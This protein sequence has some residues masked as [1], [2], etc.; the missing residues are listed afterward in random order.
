MPGEVYDLAAPPDD[1]WWVITGEAP[2]P[3]A[4]E[5]FPPDPAPEAAPEAVP[6]PPPDP[7]PPAAEPVPEPFAFPGFD[8][9]PARA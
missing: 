9:P 7:V 2:V 5:A 3:P 4:P 1:G 8:N 6:V